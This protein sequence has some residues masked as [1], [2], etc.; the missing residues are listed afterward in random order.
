MGEAGEAHRPE[1]SY[2]SLCFLKLRGC[3][4]LLPGFTMFW[5]RV[6]YCLTLPFVCYYFDKLRTLHIFREHLAI[7]LVCKAQTKL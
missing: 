2:R 3:R 7:K 5:L 6:Q 1:T 4:V